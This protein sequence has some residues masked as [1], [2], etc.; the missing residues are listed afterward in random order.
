[1]VDGAAR[2]GT[3][4]TLSHWSRSPT[5]RKLRMDLSTQ[6]VLRALQEGYLHESDT[7]LATIDHYD[8][9]GVAALG[10]L[11]VPGLAELH[12]DVLV[13]AARVGDFGVVRDRRGALVAFGLATLA[14][15]HRTPLEVPRS[16]Q[17]QRTGHLEMCGL[18]ARHALSMLEEFSGNPQ[19]FESLWREEA[20]AFDSATAGMGRWVNVE[21]LPDHDLAIVRVDPSASGARSASWGGHV[22]H[23]ASVNSST[24]RLRV[25]TIAGDHLEVRFRYESW[26]RLASFRPRPRVDLAGLASLLDKLEPHGT[27]WSFDGAGAIRPALRT[28]GGEPSGI[29]SDQFIELLVEHLAVLDAGPAAWDPYVEAP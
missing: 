1:M 15:P 11:V 6:I 25:A 29:S 28:V 4:M 10:L 9:D 16:A 26:V 23:P 7:D 8:E 22:I 2:R 3:V 12:A 20:S 19:R 18:A 24:A 14:D 21:E 5:P 27:K 13:E 17:D